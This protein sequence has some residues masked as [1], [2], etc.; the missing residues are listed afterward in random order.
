M[1]HALG[2]AAKNS[3]TMLGERAE[4]IVENAGKTV[5]VGSEIGARC[6]EGEMVDRDG[7]ACWCCCCCW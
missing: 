3:T 6:L 4:E 2:I 7:E 5:G 1:V